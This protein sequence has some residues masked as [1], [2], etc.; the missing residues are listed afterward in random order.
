MHFKRGDHTS[1]LL[2]KEEVRA[3]K[4]LEENRT[5]KEDEIF[6]GE[7]VHAEMQRQ[8]ANFLK[9]MAKTN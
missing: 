1:F 7:D 4:A 3:K 6:I 2:P 5:V 9:I 8:V